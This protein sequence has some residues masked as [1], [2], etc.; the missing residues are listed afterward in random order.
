M[1]DPKPVKVE[2]TKESFREKISD[3]LEDMWEKIGQYHM[4]VSGQAAH[5]VKPS[6][7][8]SEAENTLTYS[9]ELPGMDDGDIEVSIDSG[10]LVIR[11]E[12]RDEREESGENYIFKERRFGRFERAFALPAN[13]EEDNIKAVFDKGVLT[14]KLPCERGREKP[15][16]KIEVTRT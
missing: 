13:V 15:S 1:N 9:L 8:L 12:K 4:G 10:R 16:R 11:G 6:T 5:D 3:V 14:V 2:R 7:D